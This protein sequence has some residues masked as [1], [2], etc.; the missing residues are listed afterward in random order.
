MSRTV[1]VVAYKHVFPRGLRP[2]D[3]SC[4]IRVL[5]G[6]AWAL[7]PVDFGFLTALELHLLLF[8]PRT[9]FMS[10]LLGWS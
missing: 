2:G 8:L 6:L 7:G 3:D 1:D 5:A 4:D 9:L 10:F